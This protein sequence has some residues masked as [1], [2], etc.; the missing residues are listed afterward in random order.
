MEN[1]NN[2]DELP[3]VEVVAAVPTEEGGVPEDTHDTNPVIAI[4]DVTEELA[5]TAENEHETVFNLLSLCGNN[6]T[7]KTKIKA[8]PKIVKKSKQKSAILSKAKNFLV[9]PKLKPKMNS[10]KKVSKK[11]NSSVLKNL[12]LRKTKPTKKSK[13]SKKQVKKVVRKQVKKG[14]STKS[15]LIAVPS[16]S[17]DSKQSSATISKKKTKKP[18]TKLNLSKIKIVTKPPKTKSQKSKTRPSIKSGTS[19]RKPKLTKVNN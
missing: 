15:N 5:A 3:M 8:K 7:A 16:T 19:T 18:S 4:N 14:L 6:L 12:H 1:I 2:F 10:P 13:V 9:K 11:S 17:K